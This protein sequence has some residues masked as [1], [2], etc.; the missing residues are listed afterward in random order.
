LDALGLFVLQGFS[1]GRHGLFIQDGLRFSLLEQLIQ[2][3]HP[4]QIS[5]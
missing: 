5:K 3:G 1:Q 2:Y 4:F